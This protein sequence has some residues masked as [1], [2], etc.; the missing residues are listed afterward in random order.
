MD[1]SQGSTSDASI[2]EMSSQ[3]DSLD[4]WI[5][6]KDR[7]FLD[8]APSPLNQS[9]YGFTVSWDDAESRVI[10]TCRTLPAKSTQPKTPSALLSK[11]SLKTIRQTD[12]LQS[13][14]PCLE[15]EALPSLAPTLAGP[16]AQVG[17]FTVSEL[18]AV[19]RLLSLVHPVLSSHYPPDPPHESLG[20]DSPSAGG[21][22]S[23][24]RPI[25]TPTESDCAALCRYLSA[26]VDVCGATLV[27]STLF[28]GDETEK[29][30]EAGGYFERVGELRRRTHEEAV[31]RAEEGV[32]GVLFLR[33]QVDCS[34]TPFTF[35]WQKVVSKTGTEHEHIFDIF[36]L[37]EWHM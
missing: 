13:L 37:C 30:D 29:G 19:H 21:L 22:L 31:R 3:P 6:I 14:A 25:P 4:G 10:V 32:E 1:C 36:F 11:K 17:A 27:L 15:G 35:S 2:A 8:P 12:S 9:K 18:R 24:F 7:P 34:P 26:A 23:Y 16:P 20:Y 28:G 33:D 5:S